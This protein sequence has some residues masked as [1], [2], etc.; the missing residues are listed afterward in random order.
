MSKIT[1]AAEETAHDEIELTRYELMVLI[2]PTANSVEYKKNVEK[3]KK[4]LTDHEAAIWH[5]EEWGKRELAYTIKK[6]EDAYYLI[7]N[8][9]MDPAQMPKVEAQLRIMNFVL[10]H[11]ALKVPEGYT[12][13]TYNLDEE[14]E[15]PKKEEAVKATPVKKAAPAPVKEEKPVPVEEVEVET[16]EAEEVIEEEEVEE[17]VEE[18]AEEVAPVEVEAPKKKAVKTVEDSAAD[19]SKLDAKLEELLSGDDDLN[20]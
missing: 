12:P 9:D 5:E 6:Q 19:L 7:L 13:Q 2:N 15:R 14:V 1:T 20:L 16:E 3:I 8:F 11:L 4:L 17:V 18:V 10:R